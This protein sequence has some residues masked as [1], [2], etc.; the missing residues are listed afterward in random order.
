MTPTEQRIIKALDQI[1]YALGVVEDIVEDTL[2]QHDSRR[3]DLLHFVNNVSEL[4]SALVQELPLSPPS[5]PDKEAT[6]PAVD[7]EQATPDTENH[8]RGYF[9][10]EP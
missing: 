7:T 6:A 4:A 5:R 2:D 1:A 9:F 3:R 8:V 10:P